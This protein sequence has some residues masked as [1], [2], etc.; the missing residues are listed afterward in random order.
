MF[1]KVGWEIDESL[2]EAA[3]R[4]TFEEAGVVGEVEVQE[5]QVPGVSKAKAKA[6]FTRGTCFLCV[7][8]KNQMNG[9]RKLSVDVNG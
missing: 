7:S 6:H 8:Q 4:E 1:P 5:Y 3:S 9:L 2:E